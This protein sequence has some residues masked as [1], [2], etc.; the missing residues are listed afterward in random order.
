[1]S[2]GCNKK[3]HIQGSKQLFRSIASRILGSGQ[4]FLSIARR[5][6]HTPNIVKYCPGKLIWNIAKY[7]Y[8]YN[9]Y[10]H[11]YI[12]RG[13]VTSYSCGYPWFHAGCRVNTTLIRPHVFGSAIRDIISLILTKWDIDKEKQFLRVHYSGCTFLLRK[14][15]LGDIF[16][17]H[18]G[19]CEIALLPKFV[20]PHSLSFA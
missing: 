16:L 1:M 18:C 19:I 2:M 15:A 5:A 20:A 11:I 17:M 3:T 13:Q 9:I 12:Y 8:S 4:Y 14:G 7:F 10:T 6:I